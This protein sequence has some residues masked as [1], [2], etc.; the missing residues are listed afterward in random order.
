LLLASQPFYLSVTP[1]L[2]I[3][4]GMYVIAGGMFLYYF[5]KDPLAFRLQIVAVILFL[6]VFYAV[7]YEMFLLD[8]ILML[9]PPVLLI[10][11]FMSVFVVLTTTNIKHQW[12]MLTGGFL[13]GELGHKTFLLRYVDY[14][15]LGD[16]I[17]RDQ[18]IVALFLTTMLYGLILICLKGIRMAFRSVV[19]VGKGLKPR[20]S[21][22]Q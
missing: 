2:S 10:P 14:V 16:A 4:I 17:F 20:H 21:D 15:H 12:L 22:G 9:V 13:L 1:K 11:A 8:P 6:A 18:Y 7:A 3:H 5:Y 19:R